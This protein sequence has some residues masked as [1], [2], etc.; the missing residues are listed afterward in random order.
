MQK[1]VSKLSLNYQLKSFGWAFSGLSYFFRTELKPWL[2]FLAAVVSITMGIFLNISRAEWLFI[3]LAIA[4]V[5]MAEILNTIVERMAENIPDE[6]DLIRGRIKDMS[7]GMV[8]FTAIIALIIGAI[9]FI[10]R[11]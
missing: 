8:L 10:P 7:A 11:L 6:Q 3:V 4:L 9:V 1:K 2:H 5:F